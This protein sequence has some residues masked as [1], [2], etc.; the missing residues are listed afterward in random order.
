MKFQW[1]AGLI[2]N[3]PASCTDDHE[4]F[5]RAGNAIPSWNVPAGLK[6]R[7]VE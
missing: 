5:D 4:C 2:H 3:W 7:I 6:R 1:V